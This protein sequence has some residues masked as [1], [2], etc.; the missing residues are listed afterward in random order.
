M[1]MKNRSIDTKHPMKKNAWETMLVASLVV[2]CRRDNWFT[3]YFCSHPQLSFLI[4]NTKCSII[5]YN[6]PFC[7]NYPVYTQMS[8]SLVNT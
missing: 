5:L 4:R 8:N 3:K 2:D 6:Y 1:E 7:E